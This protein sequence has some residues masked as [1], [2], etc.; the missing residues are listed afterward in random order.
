MEAFSRLKQKI[1][2]MDVSWVDELRLKEFEY[3]STPNKKQIG[4]IAQ[5]YLDKDYSKYFIEKIKIPNDEQEYYG[6]SYG[7][8]TNA[9]IQYC[10]ELKQEINTLKNEINSLKESEK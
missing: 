2:D 4:L 5:D 7:N 9:L 8:I 3:K 6:I 1:K 10:Q